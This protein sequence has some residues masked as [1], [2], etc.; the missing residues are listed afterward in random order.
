MWLAYTARNDR[1]GLPERHSEF[2]HAA[3]IGHR[4]FCS[5]LAGEPENSGNSPMSASLGL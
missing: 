3:C 2:D 5:D 1:Q 4:A